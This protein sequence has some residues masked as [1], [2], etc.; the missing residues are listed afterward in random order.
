MRGETEATPEMANPAPLSPVGSFSTDASS[1][2]PFDV[3]AGSHRTEDLPRSAGLGERLRQVGTALN[4]LR[5]ISMSSIDDLPAEEARGRRSRS[6]SIINETDEI[7]EVPDE[8]Q[9]RSDQPP[10]ASL[11]DRFR[12]I[13]TAISMLRTYTSSK[14]DERPAFKGGS[15]AD[16][17]DFRLGIGRSMRAY[18]LFEE[19]R[20]DYIK[21]LQDLSPESREWEATMQALHRRSARKCLDLARVNG[22]LYIKVRHTSSIMRPSFL[23]RPHR[24]SFACTGGA[25]CG[26]AAGRLRRQGDPQGVRGG[27]ARV[28]GRGAAPALRGDRRGAHQRARQ[29]LTL[30]PWHQ[31]SLGSDR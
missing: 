24:R 30:V 7:D 19:I 1:P 14:N 10:R 20:V 11:R 5:G 21:S 12:Q 22:G 17:A 29:V 4:V 9:T 18:N 25:V 31:Q 8:S 23:V 16:R 2:P 6:S 27:A 13:G 15:S 3:I 28:D 26:L